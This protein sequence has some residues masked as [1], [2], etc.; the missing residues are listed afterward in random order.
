MENIVSSCVELMRNLF[1]GFVNNM[2]IKESAVI[3]N[4]K[5]S[6]IELLYIKCVH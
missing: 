4:G 2:M 6:I 5:N 1:A 3:L